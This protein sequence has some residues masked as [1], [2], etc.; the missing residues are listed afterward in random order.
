MNIVTEQRKT[1]AMHGSIERRIDAVDQ[2]LVLLAPAHGSIPPSFRNVTYDPARHARHMGE[3]QRLR[4]GIY[5]SDGAVPEEQLVNGLHRT[6]E[7]ARSWHLLMFKEK[8]E[9][10]S[11]V[12]YLP[13]EN[14]VGFD[15]LRVR[16]CPL[17]NV[18]EWRDTLVR[19]VESELARARQEQLGYA[20]LGGWAVTEDSRG[21]F[22]GLLLALA[23]YS[24][25]RIFG[26]ALGITNATVRHNSST[27]L[28]GLGG[29]S[30]EADG[31]TLAPYFDPA[32]QCEMELLR[33]DSRRP[34]A[35][36]EFMV[37]MLQ[38]KLADVVIVAARAGGEPVVRP[39]TDGHPAR[40]T[41]PAGPGPE[42]PRAQPQPSH[43][44]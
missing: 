34:N 32:Y 25:G 1:S 42:R 2:R 27:I 7:D 33:F 14:T 17:R 15:Q 8:R 6:D 35:R 29:F 38:H 10:T 30:L 9:L 12:W 23:A 13:H 41:L 24:L 21:T 16:N 28:K 5:V 20:E 22:E 3:L 26:G 37:D 31:I 36:F 39:S 4:G 44:R 11:C 40:L 18:Q 19:A 43:V